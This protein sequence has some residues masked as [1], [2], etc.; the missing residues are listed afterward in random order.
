MIRF[1][2]S[3]DCINHIIFAY[4]IN[5]NPI[6]YFAGSNATASSSSASVGAIVGGIVGVIFLIFVFAVIVVCVV[7]HS[8]R[9]RARRAT[10]AVQM[11]SI[12]AQ[13]T[14]AT[15]GAYTQS[16]P[17]A[18]NQPPPPSYSAYMEQ[19]KAYSQQT[20]PITYP[21]YAAPAGYPTQGYGYP[22][23]SYPAPAQQGFAEYPQQDYSQTGYPQQVP[24]PQKQQQETP[25]GY[26]EQEPQ[27]YGGTNPG[28]DEFTG[29]HDKPPPPYS[30]HDH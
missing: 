6:I 3:C 28:T 12:P 2:T 21:G 27:G 1:L 29:I 11:T 24:Y 18:Q 26:P 8:S 25:V 13:T 4:K 30:A 23:H 9:A 7:V 20:A 14:S 10:P 5:I 16:Q 17:E 15:T 19:Q 22:V